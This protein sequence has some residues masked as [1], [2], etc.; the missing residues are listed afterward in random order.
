MIGSLDGAV[1]FAG[2]SGQLGGP[3]DQRLFFALRSQADLVMVGATTAREEHYGQARLA[4]EVQRARVARGQVPL[5]PVAVVTRSGHLEGA[6]RLFRE[7]GP[8]PIV[9]TSAD[10]AAGGLDGLSAKA[11][12]IFAGAPGGPVDL[13]SALE[14]LAARGVSHVVCEG[15]PGLNTSLAAAGAVDE[16]CLTLSPKLAGCVG[17]RL[18]GGWLG[19]GSQWLAQA[20]PGDGTSPVDGPPITRLAEMQL[21]HVLEE[22]GFLFLRHQV[23]RPVPQSGGSLAPSEASAPAATASGP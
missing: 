14:T 3:A 9:I 1:A 15:G 6:D 8:R 16:L 13:G 18:V 20:A 12:V 23:R 4:D 17:G 7:E 22:D 19:S 21:A 11:D 2:R 10:V 5:P